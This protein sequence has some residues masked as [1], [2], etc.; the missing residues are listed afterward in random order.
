MR[1]YNNGKDNNKSDQ[2]KSTNDNTMKRPLTLDL[3]KKISNLNNPPVLSTPDVNLCKLASPDLEN[4]ILNTD[5][6]QTPSSLPTPS[7]VQ[8]MLQNSKVSDLHGSC[9]Y[10]VLIIFFLLRQVTTEQEEYAK[11]F[12]EALKNIH[13][14]ELSN[15]NVNVKPAP[16]MSGGGI[17]SYSDSENTSLLMQQIKEEPTQ[18]S[19]PAQPLNP[20][21]M[22]SQERI[23]LERK[24]QRNRVA[25]SKCRKRKLGGKFF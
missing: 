6:L 23:K 15:V 1:S 14:N 10:P 4:F 19:S 25:A 11:G 13:N 5:T 7:T 20:I 3:N 21:D 17:T 16:T 18:P 24:R 8:T 12:E 22:E 9:V 2:Q